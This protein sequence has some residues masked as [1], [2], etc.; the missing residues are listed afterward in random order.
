M[1][2]RVEQLVSP[3]IRKAERRYIGG[4]NYRPYPQIAFKGELFRSMPLER[5]FIHSEGERKPFN[6][7]AA[8]AVFFF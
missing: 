7:L 1:F 3:R 6:G 2:G 8:A 4:L 5:D